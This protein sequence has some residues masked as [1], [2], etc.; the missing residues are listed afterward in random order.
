MKELLIELNGEIKKLYSKYDFD[1]DEIDEEDGKIELSTRENGDV[2]EEE[3]S[4]IDMGNAEKICDEIL[5]DYQEGFK[6]YQVDCQIDTCDEWVHL[7]I[8]LF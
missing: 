8:S 5:T 3:Y 6:G 7:D 2:G 1:L 4:E